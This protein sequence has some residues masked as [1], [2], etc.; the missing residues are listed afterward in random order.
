MVDDFK[1]LAHSL[2]F[3]HWEQTYL[4]GLR[5]KPSTRKDRWCCFLFLSTCSYPEFIKLQWPMSFGMV[6]SPKHPWLAICSGYVQWPKT[7]FLAMF[8]QKHHVS[9]CNNKTHFFV[10]APVQRC[11]GGS[12]PI[13]FAIS[14]TTRSAAHGRDIAATWS[15][16]SGRIHLNTC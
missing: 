11:Q 14:K 7:Q 6:T 16:M 15:E 4:F 10:K 1:S 2:S 9:L 3:A 12:Q 5:C 13:G 8:Q